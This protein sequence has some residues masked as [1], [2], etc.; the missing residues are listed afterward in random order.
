M[1]I[2]LIIVGITILLIIVGLSG[3]TGPK[4][5]IEA[6]KL[7]GL[8]Y[9]SVNMTEE[10]MQNFPHLKQA[11]LT[12]KTVDVS[13]PSE[14]MSELRGILEYFNTD[15]ICYQNEYYEIQIRY[16]D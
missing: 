10:K 8:N 9:K 13:S 12:N 6:V 14:E 11:I 1:K 3:C 2:R 4:Q 7:N 5:I 16:A 15:I